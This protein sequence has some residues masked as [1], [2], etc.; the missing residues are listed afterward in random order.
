MNALVYEPFGDVEGFYL[1]QT[2]LV[3]HEFVHTH[4]KERDMEDLAD[5]GLKV[6]RRA[7]HAAPVQVSPQGANRIC[8]RDVSSPA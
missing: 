4:L 7:D 5:L 1:S 6:V 3:R 8:G 2:P